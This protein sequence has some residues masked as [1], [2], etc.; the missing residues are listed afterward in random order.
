MNVDEDEL[1]S[2]G[3]MLKIKWKPLGILGVEDLTKK[4][5]N[6]KVFCWILD[7]L[8]MLIQPIGCR[9]KKFPLPWNI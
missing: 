9:I 4:I 5:I 8:M 6:G 7:E 3:S 2:N 1:W